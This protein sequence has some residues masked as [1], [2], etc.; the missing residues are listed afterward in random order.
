MVHA[1]VMVDAAAGRAEAVLDRVSD[2]SG[3]SEAHIVA[4]NFDLVVEIDGDEPHD[5]L[6]TV[7]EGIR[8]LAD[9]GTTRTYVCLE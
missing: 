1:I 3:V 6:R 8:S 9:V 7:T 4:G 2:L 5:L